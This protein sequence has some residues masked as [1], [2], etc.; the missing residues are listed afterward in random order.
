LEIPIPDNPDAPRPGWI[1][2]G[3]QRSLALARTANGRF[4][5]PVS[6][7]ATSDLELVRDQFLRVNDVRPLPA[8][9]VTELLP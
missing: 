2:D 3:Q 6:G 8:D 9:L 1:V 5:V 7:F 4:P